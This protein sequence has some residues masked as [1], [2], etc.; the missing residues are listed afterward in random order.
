MPEF[1]GF[2][3]F[4]ILCVA[5]IV[6]GPKQLPQLARTLGLWIGRLRRSFNSFKQD[7]EREVG[8]DDVRRQLHNEQ[9]MAEMKDLEDTSNTIHQEV[10]SSFQI[11]SSKSPKSND[12]LPDPLTKSN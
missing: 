4:L 10:E 11:S 9:I 12:T 5:L 6:L 3:I 8:M 7:I 1:G 2:E